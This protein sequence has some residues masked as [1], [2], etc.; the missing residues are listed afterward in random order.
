MESTPLPKT[1][2]I[3][4]TRS[5]LWSLEAGVG[6]WELNEGDEKVQ[7]FSYKINKHWLVIYNRMSMVNIA[8]FCVWKLLIRE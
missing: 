2:L 6:G 7:S 8:I 4:K 3:T 1:N 5:D